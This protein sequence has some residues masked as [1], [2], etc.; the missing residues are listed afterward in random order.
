M[1]PCPECGEPPHYHSWCTRCAQLF[2]APREHPGITLHLHSHRER[3]EREIR[4]AH[5]E[6]LT[7]LQAAEKIGCCQ[8]CIS[9]WKRRLGL[10]DFKKPEHWRRRANALAS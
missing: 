5:A 1:K 4:A 6:G 8:A 3:M 10:P 2:M 7:A 9:N